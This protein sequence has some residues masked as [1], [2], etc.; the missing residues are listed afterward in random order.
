MPAPRAV[1]RSCCSESDTHRRNAIIGLLWTTG[2][3]VSQLFVHAVP[4]YGYL[5]DRVPQ[6][7]MPNARSFA[8]QT[9]TISNSPWLEDDTFERIC[10][11]IERQM[12]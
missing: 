11:V 5:A 1:G 3:G 2:V 12:K 7:P 4:V 6:T 9:L 10:A 8:A